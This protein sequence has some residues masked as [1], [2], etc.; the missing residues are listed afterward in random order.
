MRRETQIYVSNEGH[1]VKEVRRTNNE[2]AVR[3]KR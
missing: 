3:R 1:E 2:R